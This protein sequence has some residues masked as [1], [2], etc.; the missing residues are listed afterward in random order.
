MTRSRS[1]AVLSILVVPCLAGADWPEFRGTG[2]AATSAD[3]GLPDHWD[4]STNLLWKVKLPGQGA[5]S[6]IVFGDRVYVTCYTGE[7]GK[8]VRHLVC[9]NRKNGDVAWTKDIRS[10]TPEANYSGMM[11][12]HGYASNTPATDGKRIYVF[13]GSAGVYAFDLEGNELWKHSVGNGTDQWG[14][15]SSVRLFGDLVIVNAAIESSKVVALDKATGN[16]KWTFGVARRSWSTPAVLELDGGRK[17]LVVSSDGR[18]SGLDQNGKELWHCE[19]V[20]GYTCPSV[21]P[22]KGVAYVCGGGPNG[23]TQIAVRGGGSGDVSNTHVLWR[24]RGG[25]NVPTPVLYKGHLFGVSDRDG[26][27]F[28]LNAE[29]GDSTGKQR[30]QAGLEPAVQP[31]AYQPPGGRGRRGM[32]RGGMGRGGFPGGGFG[33]GLSFYASAVAADDKIFVP[34]RTSGIFVL[35]ADTDMKLLACN[36]FAGDDSRFD[37]TP[38]ISDGQL[39]LRSNQFLYCVGAK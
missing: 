30:L 27:A 34:S 9:V 3:A 19:G 26:V 24:K 4:K 28:C 2:G 25:A 36:K 32:G 13:L 15:G 5:S 33:G 37:G 12:Q 11:T 23:M 20:H 38:A 8:L 29:T 1:L 17:E 31:V 7:P 35:S 21:I 22:D 6:P 10:N 16:E 18:V 39:F 14:S